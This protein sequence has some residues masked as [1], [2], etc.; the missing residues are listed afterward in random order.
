M[1]EDMKIKELLSRYAD[2]E[3]TPE[4]KE[5]AEKY[6]KES[7]EYSAYYQKL[8]KLDGVLNQNPFEP[9]SPDWESQIRSSLINGGEKQADKPRGKR[10]LLR[11]GISGALVSILTLVAFST[12]TF[13]LDKFVS[14]QDTIVYAQDEFEA[15]SKA[16][17]RVIT[18]NSKDSQP[19]KNAEITVAIRQPNTKQEKVV[20]KGK[21]PSSGSP[22]IRF[23]IPDYKEGQYE[24]IVTA[25]SQYGH[26]KIIKPIKIR[27]LSKVL[28]TTDKSLYQPGQ[29]IY[30]RALALKSSNSTPIS[31][32][33]MTFEVE[34]PK[35]NKVFKK[36]ID[37]SE[38]GVAGTTFTLAN[39]INMGSYTVRASFADFS[40]EKKVEVKRYVLPKFKINFKTD[41]T[42]YLPNQTLKGVVNTNYFFGKPTNNAKV[43]I[44][45][46]TYEVNMELLE[47]INGM[48]NEEG[49]FEFEYRLPG[50]FVGL[51]L[52]KG[53]GLLFFDISVTDQAQHEEKTSQSVPVAKD[54]VAIEFIPE[55]G[56]LVPNLENIIYGVT[57]YP[58]GKP[59]I[60]TVNVKGQRVQTN[61]FGIAEIKVKDIP[62]PTW[63]SKVYRISATAQDDHGNQ[64][65][66]TKELSIASDNNIASND[67]VLLRTDRSILDVGE[68]I[69]LQIFTSQA[70]GTVYLDVI[71]NKQTILTKALDVTDH[72][73]ELEL[74]LDETMA[75]TLELHAYKVLRTSDIVRDTKTIFVNHK[76]DLQ[77]DISAD[78]GTYL[79]G[80]MAKI[81]FLTSKDRRGIPSALGVN[82]VDESVFALQEMQPGFERLYFALEKE[83]M[84]PRAELFMYS[85]PGLIDEKGPVLDEATRIQIGN[86]LLSNA[87][88]QDRFPIQFSSREDNLAKIQNQRSK[89]F[90][91]IFKIIFFILISLPLS[92]LILTVYTY[93][94]KKLML[95]KDLGAS[96]LVLI[97][98]ILLLALI[99]FLLFWSLQATARYINPGIIFLLIVGAII[100]A[101][102]VSFIFLTRHAQRRNSHLLW[103]NILGMAYIMLLLLTVALLAIGQVDFP[104]IEKMFLIVLLSGFI[105]AILYAKVALEFIT[106]RNRLAYLALIMALFYTQAFVILPLQ[107]YVKRGF[108]GRPR[109]AADDIG[110]QYE[111]YYLSK[112]YS[113][114]RSESGAVPAGQEK[115]RIRQFFPETLYSNPQ[116]ITDQNGKASI[117]LKVADSITSWRITALANSLNGNIGS[118]NLAMIVFQDFFVDIDLPV[119][120]TQEDEVS[121]PIAVYNYLK[122]PQN[123]SLELKQEAWFELLDEPKKSV[124]I[125]TNGIDVVYFRI[126]AK[127]L[128]KHNLTVLAYGE[129]KG[130]AISRDIEIAPDGKEISISY[131][132]ML[133]KDIEKVINVPEQTIDD[134]QRLFV[135]I[136]P[137]IFAQVVEGLDSMLQMPY[138][139]FEQTSSIT[140]PNLLALDYMKSTKQIT[141][142]IQMKAEHYISTGYQRLLTF[143]PIKGGFS[144]FGQNPA[145]RIVTA[146]GLM[147]FTDMSK[148]YDID[149]NLI[150]RIQQWLL[151]QMEGDHWKPDGHYGAAYKARNSN[152]GATSYITWALLHSG[153]P[154][155]DPRIQKVLNFIEREYKTEEDNPYTLA[156]AV[157][158]LSKAKRNAKPIL[159]R[160]DSLAQKDNGMI[161]W[162]S[163]VKSEHDYYMG[164]QKVNWDDVET[165]ALVALA[166]LEENYRLNDLTKVTK[167]LVQSKDSRGNWGSTQATVLSMKALLDSITKASQGVNARINVFVDN[168]KVQ[169][170][171]MNEENKDVLQLIDLKSYAKKGDTNLHIQ[172]EGKGGLLYQIVSAYFLK[173]DDYRV[174][175]PEKKK[176]GINIQLDYDKVELKTNDIITANVQVNYIGEGVINYGM[177]DLGIPP[178][179]QVL[180]EDLNKYVETEQIEKFEMT[181]RQLSIYIEKLDSK[182]LHLKYRLQA[183]FPIKGKTPKSSVFDYYNPDLKDEVEPVEMNVMQ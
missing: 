157:L 78:K 140:Y 183:K 23:D 170:I 1:N 65:S 20:Y 121:I 155:D 13:H 149:N 141:P 34:D 144:I 158:S 2:G 166:Y 72:V 74:D 68:T 94:H 174:F 49:L 10:L 8:K 91:L 48:T 109:S 64:G 31:Q 162:K 9:P 76:N 25:D 126:K 92:A 35:D 26:D 178:G 5:I 139:C 57:S 14:L 160:L 167:Y 53:S 116:I 171:I 125:G 28:L 84:T 120:L 143:E 80:E 108:Q 60:T 88:S 165:T 54:P 114:V 153:L 90:N 51:P 55:S 19:I 176:P 147:E 134:S 102:I 82:I 15:G 105:F 97:G 151:N 169:E 79:P 6:I 42:Y 107:M 22:E 70:R 128:G 133:D 117:D 75:G 182:G 47:V 100:A 136:Y 106:T 122:T 17:L 61:Q 112:E 95:L 135:K 4:E 99:L 67:S 156:L 58:D 180:T 130:D 159:E 32:A 181:G 81:S 164:G 71:K 111:P 38:F 12:Y 148:V 87:T 45:V 98:A 168:K 11:A 172:F 150:P 29:S 27:K 56:D 52:E 7:P 103:I 101:Y 177:I 118:S 73:S 69:H 179:F 63:N 123:V 86:V 119:T 104:N 113:V 41:R 40:A 110:D 18:L 96:F 37:T 83:L 59:A 124:N 39:E 77:L 132:D 146:Y 21:A 46:R 66:A 50:H 138:G 24:L 89:Y 161:Y 152:V 30:I 142:E 16:G 173:W 131:S 175:G 163:S 93:R 85:V 145:E 115:P 36:K 154:K 44:E 43:K 62:F 137:G 127:R 33:E 129:K 3:V